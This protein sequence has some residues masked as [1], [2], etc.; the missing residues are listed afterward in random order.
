MPKY[1]VLRKIEVSCWI[2][3]DAVSEK[4]ALEKAET[5]RQ[6]WKPELISQYKTKEVFP[7][8]IFVDEI[9]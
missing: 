1:Q 6:P 4:K 7:E 5:V 8:T 3:I 2:K 9:W